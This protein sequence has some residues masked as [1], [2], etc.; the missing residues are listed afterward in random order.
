MIL[1][2]ELNDSGLDATSLIPKNWDKVRIKHLVSTKVTDGPHE[3]P[4]FL[5][6]GVPFL[7][8]EGVVGNKIDFSKIRGFIS[9]EVHQQYSRKCKPERGDVLLVKSG[10]TT[11]KSTIVETDEEFNIW[12]PLC[13]LRSDQEKIDPYFLVRTVQSEFFFRQ[14]QLGWSFG[15]QPNIGMG[16]VE[17]L[18][19]ICPPLEEQKLISQY[20]NKKT[21]QI[22]SLIEKIQK[23]IVLL[24][25]QRTSLINQ[26]V[27]KGL[28]SNVEM[29]DSGI[30]WIGEIPRHWDSLPV[31]YVTEDHRQ[32]FYT[33]DPYDA[34]GVPILRITDIQ[35][36]HSFSHWESPKYSR[37]EDEIYKFYVK[38]GAFLF[39][40]TGGVGRFGI[41][42]F[43]FPCIYGSFMIR[44][45][46]C[47]SVNR[48]F[49]KFFLETSLF[50]DQVKQE[51]H[52][53]VNQNV[54]VE[55]IKDVLFF[56]PPVE[57]QSCISD[58]LKR[59]C[60]VLDNKINLERNRVSLLREYR[61]SLISS[62]VTGKVRVTED[63]I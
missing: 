11:G 40:R 12:S 15:T 34:E 62:V 41:L 52:G 23:K 35:E 20:L 39:P 9:P 28:N 10:S 4:E 1:D 50:T 25:E 63:M 38:N 31:R 21:T 59:K 53:G 19:V 26:Y 32:G 47:S 27:T 16:V 29:K 3:T 56:R 57:E 44:F 48:N 33:S 45:R 24:K 7:S 51:I 17:N 42:N 54:H 58:Y 6:T 14:I 5:D 46:W 61:Q 2:Y 22:D 8:V 55:N 37:S 49:M 36:D 13:I 43:D 60:S 30:E 18:W